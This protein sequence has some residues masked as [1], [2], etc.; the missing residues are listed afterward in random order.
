[1]SNFNRQFKRARKLEQR[2]IKKMLRKNI[3]KILRPRPNFWPKFFYNWVLKK[4]LD[5]KKLK[6]IKEESHE[7]I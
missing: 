4:V 1:M 3:L 5:I 7:H 2:A 6:S